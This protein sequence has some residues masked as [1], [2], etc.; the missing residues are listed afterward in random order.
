MEKNE[1]KKTIKVYKS[2]KLT[3]N[4]ISINYAVLLG[5]NAISTERKIRIQN[6]GGALTSLYNY[7][8]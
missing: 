2:H 3:D 5:D 4:Y 7:F 6:T 8:N 1:F